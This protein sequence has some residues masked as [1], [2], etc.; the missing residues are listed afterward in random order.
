[1]QKFDTLMCTIMSTP[2]IENESP[3]YLSFDVKVHGDVVP[4]TFVGNFAHALRNHIRVGDEGIIRNGLVDNGKLVF[5]FM[6]LDPSTAVGRNLN[7]V[8]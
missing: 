7:V 8:G 3:F 5:D 6:H 4:A 2:V 1:M